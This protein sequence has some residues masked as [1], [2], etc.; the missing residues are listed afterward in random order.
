MKFITALLALC[1]VSVSAFSQVELNFDERHDFLQGMKTS[2]IVIPDLTAQ[3]EIR[4]TTGTLLFQIN[5]TPA[6]NDTAAALNTITFGTAMQISR[7][8]PVIDVTG[9]LSVSGKV[10][11]GEIQSVSFDLPLA[12]SA[13][14]P[15]K[16]DI[17]TDFVK[18][19][20]LSSDETAATAAL[21]IRDGTGNTFYFFSDNMTGN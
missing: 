2:V 17:Q 4:N 8:S 13:G 1:F 16:W 5:N 9:E 20:M 18:M 7:A 21:V 15:D 11:S 19:F 14:I 6:T 3:I 12:P 10:T